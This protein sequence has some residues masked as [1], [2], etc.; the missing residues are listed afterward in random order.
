MSEEDNLGLSKPIGDRHHREGSVPL[1]E[2]DFLNA[3][4]FN[5]SGVCRLWQP[6]KPQD[7]GCGSRRLGGLLM[8]YS[9]ARNYVDLDPNKGLID[10]GIR[11]EVGSSLEGRSY[12]RLAIASL[13]IKTP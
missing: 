10:K 11:P 13:K 12:C 6:H 1:D 4:F 5:V 7:I 2:Y 3:I 9:T 8:P